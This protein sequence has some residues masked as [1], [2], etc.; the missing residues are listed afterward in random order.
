MSI[1]VAQEPDDLAQF[2]VQFW[3]QNTQISIK[4]IILPHGVAKLL[5]FSVISQ[6]RFFLLLSDILNLSRCYT[7][8]A[9]ICNVNFKKYKLEKIIIII[10]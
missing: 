6:I 8:C 9:M 7:F 5:W 10:K 3:N 1:C 2:W 4:H